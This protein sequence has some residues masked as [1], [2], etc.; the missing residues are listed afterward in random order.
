MRKMCQI[1]HLHRRLRPMSP[2]AWPGH[3]NHCVCVYTKSPIRCN[4]P[5]CNKGKKSEWRLIALTAPCPWLRPCIDV[6][7]SRVYTRYMYSRV[8]YKYPWRVTCL[9][10]SGAN[11]A[12]NTTT[13]GGLVAPWS[14]SC[15]W[16]TFSWPDPTHWNVDPT[17]PDPTRPND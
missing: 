10:V 15:P 17:R 6:T 2:S 7:Y 16:V 8:V 5:Q 3:F 13:L 4:L 1:S 14:V 11:A 12:F 9:H